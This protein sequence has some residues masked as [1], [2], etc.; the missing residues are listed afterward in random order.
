MVRI[1]AS[2]IPPRFECP[3][4]AGLILF[5]KTAPHQKAYDK[6]TSVLRC[7]HC[8][9]RWQLGIIA[10]EL[11]PSTRRAIPRDL[12]PTIKQLAILRRYA[13]GF[14]MNGVKKARE[15]EVHRVIEEG[16][17]CA[18]L[19]WRAGCAVHGAVGM[20]EVDEPGEG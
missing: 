10:W 13:G 4:C 20:A 1:Y 7:P 19:P 18:P 16:C 3:H 2:L 5:G 9:R 12:K 8:E 14:W 17:S 11:I 6:L 15:A